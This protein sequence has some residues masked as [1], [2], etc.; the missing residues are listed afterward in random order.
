MPEHIVVR[1]FFCQTHQVTQ[2]NKKQKFDCKLCG[3]KQSV[4]A[5]LASGTAGKE[6]REV[7]QQLNFTK[8]KE[9]EALRLQ[10]ADEFRQSQA[11]PLPLQNHAAPETRPTL[12]AA[13][14]WARFC[15]SAAP[16]QTD[17]AVQE[18][19]GSYAT[20]FGDG[21]A[22]GV[23]RK[24]KDATSSDGPRKAPRNSDEV[25]PQSN[26]STGPAPSLARATRVPTPRSQGNHLQ[27]GQLTE[28]S[29]GSRWS[30][31]MGS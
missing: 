10:R 30:R 9:A 3:A 28:P 6:L 12:D 24:R 7:V 1:C 21:W 31:F 26:A 16:T 4:K 13:P 17:A 23:R 29:T 18:E 11:E 2:R 22:V 5:V 15:E 27:I 8:G 19:D 14:K 20:N 25:D